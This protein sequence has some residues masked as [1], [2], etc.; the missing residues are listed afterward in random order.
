MKEIGLTPR[1]SAMVRPDIA[2][3]DELLKVIAETG[4]PTVC[5]GLES[6]NPESLKAYEKHQTLEDNISSIRKIKS[7][8]I[9]IH[10][11]FVFGSDSDTVDTI[12]R[13]T[14]FAASMGID[15]VQYM[16]LTPLPGTKIYDDFKAQDRLLHTDWAMY[17]IHHVVYKPALITAND[18]HFETLEAMRGFYSWD[19][20]LR[21]ISRLDWFYGAF[22][23]Y[24]RTMINRAIKGADACVEGLCSL[25]SAG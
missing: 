25:K 19:Y 24:S 17:D 11:M 4:K 15:S 3:D 18:L 5:I 7:H 21:R 22:G 12:K 23:I 8:G 9:N 13:T 10:G 14:E 2:K 20:I 6:I 1:W 16:I